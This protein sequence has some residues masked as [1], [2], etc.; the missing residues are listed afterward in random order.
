MRILIFNWR[1]IRN[2]SGGGAEILTHEM[3]KRW[4][5][6]GHSVIQFSSY[7]P[8][9]KREEIIDGVKIIRRGRSDARFLFWSVHFFAF[10]YYFKYFKNK[11]DVIIDEIHGFPFFTPLYVKEKKIALICEVANDLWFKV[12]GHISGAI[13]RF[14]EIVYLRIIYNNIIFVTISKSSEKELIKNGISKGRVHVLPMGINISLTKERKEKERIF[15]LL[16]IGRLSKP[17][18]IEDALHVTSILK[19]KGQQVQ[20]KI[21]GRGE[22]E[23]VD[24]LLA[25]RDKLKISNEVKFLGYVSEKKKFEIISS[26]HILISPSI[27][28]GF[29]LTIPE[30]GRMGIPSVVY[31]SLGL[32]DIVI[33]NKNGLICREN[34]P[35]SLSEAVILLLADT[36]L[37]RK[38]A[39]GAREE[40]KKYNWDNTAGDML[41]LLKKM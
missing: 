14:I 23:Y 8:R 38:L 10:I 34:T 29:G 3:E 40:S 20:L 32:S 6:S 21:I 30:A 27:K 9:A 36:A 24:F 12:Y 28:E 35:Q 25:L 2:P 33:N 1:D 18:G 41:S 15:T 4:V 7:F 16:Y 17:K 39:E 22:R 37:Y 13:G 11:F 31:N 26:S 5:A 19:E